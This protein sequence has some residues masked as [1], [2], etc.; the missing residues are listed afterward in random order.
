MGTRCRAGMTWPQADKQM[1][2]GARVWLPEWPKTTY[3][4]RVA[5]D[6]YEYIVVEDGQARS[7]KPGI[8]D[9]IRCDWLAAFS[10]RG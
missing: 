6:R 10:G 8:Q 4:E 5:H 1:L 9:A 7:W 2:K 3:V